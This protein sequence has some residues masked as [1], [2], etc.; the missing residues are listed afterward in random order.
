MTSATGGDTK[1]EVGLGAHAVLGV[2][3]TTFLM[4]VRDNPTDVSL[5][6]VCEGEVDVWNTTG[7]VRDTIVVGAGQMTTVVV[8]A[9]PEEPSAF[10]CTPG[11]TEWERLG[12]P[13]F[14][15]PSGGSN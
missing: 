15:P 13:R 14:V 5:V 6:G 2:R 10:D 8:G 11:W 3:G 7:S 9:V 1:Y 12:A 4:E